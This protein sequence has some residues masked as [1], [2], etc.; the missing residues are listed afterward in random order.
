MTGSA[1]AVRLAGHVALLCGLL[2]AGLVASSASAQ[3]APTPTA[4]PDDRPPLVTAPPEGPPPPAEPH[5]WDGNHTSVLVGP[6]VNWLDHAPSAVDTQCLGFRIAAR[7]G[8]ITQFV[9]AELGFERVTH[10]GQNGAGLTRN[11]VGFQVGTHPAF[12]IIVF[13]DWWN[14]V[15]AGIHGYVGA[16]VAR[17]TL[18]GTEALAQAQV[19]E[20]T[21]HA[22][23]QPS[24]YVGA[25]MDIPVSPRNRDWGIWLTARYNLRWLWF[26]PKQPEMTLSDSQALLLLSF[27]SNS[28]SWARIPRPF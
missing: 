19:F 4:D 9:D 21:E 8:V 12:P 17:L 7:M 15:I 26:G 10:G 24:V 25:G 23:W 2:L 1:A 28:T 5:L 11:E 16:S 18:T 20:G 3:E 6:V 27:R 22:E 14:D 13:N